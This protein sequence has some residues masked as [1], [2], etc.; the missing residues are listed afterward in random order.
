MK[1]IVSESKI[2]S[3]TGRLASM[4]HFLN[5]HGPALDGNEP[6]YGVLYEIRLLTDQLAC[7]CRRKYDDA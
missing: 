5:E 1:K 4:L 7:Q 6:V 3:I 2:E